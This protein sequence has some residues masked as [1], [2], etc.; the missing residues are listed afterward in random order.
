MFSFGKIAKII[1][2]SVSFSFKRDIHIRN[3]TVA[4]LQKSDQP[5]NPINEIKRD[6]E[7]FTL[8]RGMD[9]LM[10]HYVFVNP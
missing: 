1:A 8:L 3:M 6:E 4:K 9:T 10:I 2:I 7:Q 5:F